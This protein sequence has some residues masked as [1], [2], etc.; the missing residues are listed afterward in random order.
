MYTL[1]AFDIIFFSCPLFFLYSKLVISLWKR[2]KDFFSAFYRIVLFGGIVDCS[3][4]LLYLNLRLP[5]TNFYFDHFL[6][7]FNHYS[8]WW[9]P[10]KFVI[11]QFIFMGHTTSLLMAVNR[12]TSLYLPLHYDHIW[13][14][15]SLIIGA[16]YLVIPTTMT[17]QLLFKPAGFIL[18]GNRTS[19][20][21]TLEYDHSYTFGPHMSTALVWYT[22]LIALLTLTFNLMCAIKMIMYR[23]KHKALTKNNSRMVLCA[24]IVFLNEVMVMFSQ[25]IVLQQFLDKTFTMRVVIPFIFDIHCL[26]PGV[27]VLCTVPQ[28]REVTVGAFLREDLTEKSISVTPAVVIAK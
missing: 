27:I 2:R 24:M 4:F 23:F 5:N 22:M 13:Q 21:V 8:F 20:L 28:L 19:G 9:S 25:V 15:H 10:L 17:W 7:Y 6:D 26:M 16:S 11:Y 18:M 14:K 1:E 3:S 12:V